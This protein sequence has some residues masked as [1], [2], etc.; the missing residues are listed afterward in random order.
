MDKI[1]PE[2]ATLIE[3]VAKTTARALEESYA[4]RIRYLEQR[5]LDVEG[6]LACLV[7]F[8]RDRSAFVAEKIDALRAVLPDDPSEP[9]KKQRLLS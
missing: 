7:A 1:P 9:P 3:G 5:V 8:V 6:E 4:E 2:L